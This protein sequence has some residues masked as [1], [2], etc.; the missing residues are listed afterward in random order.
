MFDLASIGLASADPQTGQ[1][2]RMNQK[3]CAIT[4]YSASELL[5]LRVPEL[6]HPDDRQKDWEEFQRVVRGEVPD[7]RLEKRYLRKDG[8]VA[9]VNVN[10]TVIRDA[11]GQPMRT[12]AT[13]EDITER[14]QAEKSL[15]EKERRY[16]LLFNSGYDAV[17]VHQPDE[18]GNASGKFIEV[19]DIACQRLGYTREELL[20]LTPRDISAPE[21]LADIPRIRAKLAAEESAVSE[22]VH[23]TK[24]GRRIPVEI[25]THVFEL[26][27]KPT[28][29]SAVRDITERKQAEAAL[30]E[31]VQFNQQI[32]TSAQEGIIVYGRDLKYQVWNPFMEQLSGVPVCQV[33]GKHPDELF[34][35][36][37]KAGMLASI[38]KALAGE[39]PTAIDF[40]YEGLPNGRSGWCCETNG[41]LRNAAGEIVGVIGIVRD[42][43][44]RKRA[45]L[46]ITA[47]ANLGQRLNAA[48][49]AR[50]AGE[51]I[52]EVADELLGW[53]ACLFDLYSAAEN[54]ITHLLNMDLVDGRRTE[55]KRQYFDSS[56]RELSKRAIEEGGQLILRDQ[57]EA[58]RPEGSRFGDMSRP[59]ASLMFVPVRH[60]TAVVGV[61][62]IQSYKPRAY[63]A[64][65]L[66]ALQA[67]ADYAGGALVRLQAQEALGGSEATFRS[68]WERSIDGMRLTDKEGR[69]I[70]VNEA[71]CQLVKLPREKLEGQMFSVVYKGHGA[72]NGI[73]LY[74]KRFAIGDIVPHLTTRAQLWNGEEADL[75]ISSS[76][77][78]LGQRGKMLLGI[79]RD[80]SE[81]KR[82]ELQVEAFSHLGQKLSAARSPAEAARAIYA[83]ADR[84]WK[85]DCGLLDLAMAES[86]RVE[87]V[88]AYDMVD[89]QRCEVTPSDPTAPVSAM[90]RRVMT[91]G[92]EL[93]LRQPAEPPA[94]DTIRFGDASRLSASIMC[95]P[96]RVENQAMG[97]LSIQ[98]Y[99]P[100][101]Y[102]QQDLQT[103]QALADHCGGALDRLRME[104]AWQTTQQRLGHLL[105]QS[106]TVIYSLKTDGKT[107]KPSWVSDNVE[108]LLGCT[109]AECNGPEGLFGQ[110]HPQD[111][112]EVIDGLI[113]LLAKKQISRDY[114]IRHKNGE[115][116]WVRDEQRLVCDAAGAPVEIVGSW[117]DI[118]ERKALEEQ[119]RQ[120]QKMEAVGQL[121]GGVAHDFNNMLAVIR[122]NAEL[123]LMD[124]DQHTAETRESLK[125]VVAASERAANLTRQLLTFSRK[126]IMQAQPLVLNEVIANLTKMLKRV[127]SENIELQCHY[128]EPLPYV[129]AD[130]GM[131]EQVILNLVVNARDAMP[132]G[133]QLRVVTE[134]V[135]LNEAH[136]RVNPEARAGEFACLV[137]S[138][139][140]TGIDPEVLPH[141]FEP[142]FTT[143]EIGKG[144]GLGLA[145]VYGIVK[146]H[147]GWIEVSSQ[148]GEGSTFRVFLPAIPT[149]AQPMA[150]SEAGAAIRGGKETIL[151]VEDEHAVRMAT[152]RVLESK[153]YTIR[154]AASAREALELWQC[155]AG[156]I[157]L[158]LTDI[159]MPGEMTGRELAE[160][161]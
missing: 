86:G 99:T 98:S 9:W 119:L 158:L 132:D 135:A 147:Q 109:V 153:G 50:E 97:V 106:P 20:Q 159:I 84:F 67:L 146:Q 41:P 148:V 81:R 28:R 75:E 100:N 72:A 49:T 30:R 134:Q 69:I 46:R 101:A 45:E 13:I 76:F 15:R 55:C 59:S 29:L 16:R 11:A 87:T 121:A 160:R 80:V 111:R 152:Q 113:Q 53:D 78:E 114:R 127:I 110:V 14:K 65:S 122:G 70:A 140:G 24:D 118:T 10:M 145:T 129:Q 31:S 151:L 27:G 92:G 47:F 60:G 61:L 116:R 85:W 141:I 137:V 23:I 51:I 79:F 52:V 102:T 38:Q 139:T 115:Y 25:S 128:A 21:T 90:A 44:E 123:L 3:M 1:W 105:A 32:V 39:P 48:K 58:M 74:H 22:G 88:L 62:S 130:T 91:G 144:T 83:S 142:F 2:L 156:E 66:E 17:F 82:A 26:N 133:G 35:F 36:L 73:E 12:M 40:H 126:Q 54:R 4:G 96:V 34:P 136:A 125:H 108:R 33:L 131:I 77:I 112:Q 155:H 71:F 143:K 120:S 104:E 18:G 89:G 42:I 8:T 63:D 43:T 56:P 94:T 5:R 117:V 103:L 138:D 19:N 124:E 95:V 7:Y 161:L 149:P 64:Y 93:I 157:A 37:R 154:E 150:T 57:P 68:V 107:T 6:T